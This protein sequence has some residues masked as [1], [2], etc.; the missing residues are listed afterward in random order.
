MD[1]ALDATK[2]YSES[3]DRKCLPPIQYERRQQYQER[4]SSGNHNMNGISEP[5]Q[6]SDE[7]QE[8]DVHSNVQDED[9]YDDD[10][11]EGHYRT[12]EDTDGV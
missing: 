4:H 9:E 11:D 7:Q 8:P 3:S 10:V 12:A 1:A 6:Q 5:R 2:R